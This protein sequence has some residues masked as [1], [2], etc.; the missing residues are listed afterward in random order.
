M[1]GYTSTTNLG[2]RKTIDTGIGYAEHER[3]QANETTNADLIESIF[4][5]AQNLVTNATIPNMNSKTI[6][7]LYGAASSLLS[8]V[9]IAGCISGVPFTLINIGA[10]TSWAI[11]DTGNMKLS[12]IYGMGQNDTLTLVWDG[13]SYYEIA[14]ATN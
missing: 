5:G 12:A 2:L 9:T 4:S 13:T 6:G 3:I 14:R 1:S 10:N 8:C 7:K 11:H